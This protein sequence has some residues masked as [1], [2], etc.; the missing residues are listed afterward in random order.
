M[1]VKTHVLQ[2]FQSRPQKTYSQEHQVHLLPTE[3]EISFIYVFS[4]LT[5]SLHSVFNVLDITFVFAFFAFIVWSL[6]FGG[7]IPMGNVAYIFLIIAVALFV[8]WFVLRFLW[9]SKRHD[10]SLDGEIV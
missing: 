10:V 1:E 7:L 4:I 9:G 3:S 8:I 2:W 6:G 5:I